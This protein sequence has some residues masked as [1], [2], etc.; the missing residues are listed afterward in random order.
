MTFLYP[1]AVRQVDQP[2]RCKLGPTL[3]L[4]HKHINKRSKKPRKLKGYVQRAVGPLHFAPILSLHCESC[5][6]SALPLVATR[7]SAASLNFDTMADLYLL[8]LSRVLSSAAM[9]PCRATMCD[10]LSL[11]V[12]R[13]QHS[14]LPVHILPRGL[15]TTVGICARYVINLGQ[16]PQIS[17]LCYTLHEAHRSEWRQLKQCA[18]HVESVR[19][20]K[21]SSTDLKGVHH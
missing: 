14:V 6:S 7:L 11:S 21:P 9:H 19:H 16:D 20:I 18:H 10:M 13:T 17:A 4:H 2:S 8:F 1:A 15:P 5:H 3:V 12:C